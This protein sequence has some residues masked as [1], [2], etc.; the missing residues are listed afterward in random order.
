M[1]ERNIAVLFLMDMSGSTKGWV[2]DAEKE[3]LV[4][5]CEAMESLGD[6]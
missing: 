6:R 4:L 1:Q 2:N 3:S 5:M